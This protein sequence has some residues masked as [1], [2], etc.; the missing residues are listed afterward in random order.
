LEKIG[1]LKTNIDA[2]LL[3]YTQQL[4]VFSFPIFSPISLSN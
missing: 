1:K 2:R 4:E 3:P